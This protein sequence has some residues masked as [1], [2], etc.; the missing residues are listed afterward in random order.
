MIIDFQKYSSVRIGKPF[1]VQVLDEICDFKG[2]LIGGANNLLISNEPKN[3]GILGKKFD[4]IEILDED[5]SSCTLKIGCATK[6]S[7][8]YH[9]A[10]Q[11]DLKGFEFLGKIPGLL[12]GI[13]KMNA[14]LKEHDISKN[15]LHIRSFKGE[16]SKEKANFS[17]RF[18][19]VQEPMFEAVFK[20]KKSFDFALDESLKTARANQPSGA[21]FGSIFKNPKGDFAGRMIEAVGLKG[22]SKGGAMIS[23]KHANF[24]INKKNASFEDAFFLITLAKKRVF[25]EFGVSLEEEVVII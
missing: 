19:G 25:E 10:K 2:F 12:G 20:L 3:L 17:Y 1:E 15:L 9:F 24:L 14:G 4:F 23:D 21:S 11:K 8:I 18:C 5:T 7:Q 16:I 22:F 13:L 6:S